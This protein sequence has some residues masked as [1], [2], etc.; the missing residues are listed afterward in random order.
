M[1]RYNRLP[2]LMACALTLMTAVGCSKSE[3]PTAGAVAP[4]APT[5]AVVEKFEVGAHAY[6]RSLHVDGDRLFVGTSTGVLEINRAS[7]DMVRTFTRKDGMRNNYA[8]VVR[9]GPDGAIWMG[10]NAG[11]LSVWR[12]NAMHNYL[13]KHGLADLWI[14]DVA[15]QPGTVWLATWDGV[16]RISGDMDERSNWTTLNTED[17]LANPWVYAIQ[18]DRE[19]AVWFGT[20]GGLSRLKDDQWTTWLHQD[21]MGA[22]N[23]GGL[24]RSPRSG[25]G[26][27]RADG[28][29]EEPPDDH[30]HD[31][32]NLTT[33]DGKGAETYNENYV[34][35]LQLDTAGFLWIGTWGGGISR[36]D[37]K[38]FVNYSTQDGLAGNVVYGI[39]QTADGAMWFATNHGIS[40]FDGSAWSRYTRKD[41]LIGED[42]YTIKAAGNAIWAGQK[43]GVLK[44]VQQ[45]T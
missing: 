38:E 7:G 29:S 10:T 25:F 8:F 36:F 11:G 6:V 3:Q 2:L 32:T 43:G 28:T 20:E 37:G 23:P 16:N 4:A 42:V 5:Y 24:S 45:P 22:E 26:S 31:L 13:P 14:Y 33:K 18:I 21:G 19:G 35:S 15:F 39:T 1:R 40:R 9:R 17:G 44:L 27:T 30:S 12:D 41:G 34:F